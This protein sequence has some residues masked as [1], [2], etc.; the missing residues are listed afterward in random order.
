MKKILRLS[1]L[2]MLCVISCTYATEYYV[3][4]DGND[5]NPGT[6]NS[7]S[8]AFRTVTKACQIA[9]PGDIVNIANGR[10]VE[11]QINIDNKNGSKSTRLIIRSINKHGAVI[12]STS[13]TH[14]ISISNSTGVTIDGLEVTFD[15]PANSYHFGILASG[16]GNWI[17]V[18][19]C[20]VHD[21]GSS[22]IQINNADHVLIEGNV[23]RHNAAN[24]GNPNGS[25]ISVY[26]PRH[27]SD[28]ITG[29][30]GVIIRN[31]ICF[32]NVCSYADPANGSITDAPT[33]GNGI[34]LDDFNNTQTWNTGG[35]T[36]GYIHPSLVENNLS[37]NN[38]GRGI[39][40]FQTNY[41]T[42]R[43]NT[44]YHNNYE[45][46]KYPQYYGWNGDLN[47]SRES[48]GC[49]FYNNIAVMKSTNTPGYGLLVTYDTDVQNNIVIGGAG[50]FTSSN[51]STNPATG[52]L[53]T[54]NQIRVL[55]D[56]SYI[57]FVNPTYA[58]TSFSS[59]NPQLSAYFGLQ[60]TSPA[61]NAGLNSQS[62]SSDLEGKV[63]PI[64]S[65]VDIGAYE[66]GTPG[67]DTQAPTAPSGLSAS[68]ITQTSFTLSWIPSTD[69]VAVTNY[70]IF[71]GSATTPVATT[72][73]TNFV[74][75]GLI[76][77]TTY[78]FTVKAKDAAGNVSTAS[79]AL[80]VTTSAPITGD[81]LNGQ[82]YTQYGP[83]VSAA[84]TA[85]AGQSPAFSFT[86]TTVDYP[87]G[88]GTTSPASTLWST[89]LG[90]DGTGAPSGEQL[91][92]STLKLSGYIQIKPEHD[93]QTG[94]ST[95][96]VDF[97]LASQGYAALTVNGT[98]V[99]LNEANWA[100]GT[101]SARV[102]FPSA[103]YYTIEVLNSV[104][105]DNGGVELYS[106]IP[107]TTNPGRG[108]TAATYLIPQIYLFKTIPPATDTQAP[109][110]P[111][112]LVSSAITQTS[113][114]LSWSAST[115]NV[116]VTSYDIFQGS[117]T[118]PIGNST[119]TSYTVNGLTA[120]TTYSF[121]VKAKDAA[122]NVSAAS[123]A[124][125]VTTSAPI[126]GDGLNGQFYTQYGPSVSAART[127]IAGQTPAFSFTSNAVDYPSGTTTTSS[128]S[129]TWSTFLGTDGTGAPSGEQLET[130][131]LKLS[132]YIQIKPEHDVQ[133][134]NSTI[135]VDF[136]LASQGYAALTVNGTQ[137]VL[138]EAN[139]AFGT[140]SARVSFPSAG[141]Y[142]IEVLNSV[143]WDNGG[144]ELYSSIPGTTNPGRGTTA[145][146]YLIPKAVLFK[147]I[148]S[149]ARVAFAATQ[150]S[151]ESDTNFTLYPNPSVS[152]NAVT[153][154]G[155]FSDTKVLV[156]IH[157]I[158]G[159]V[160]Y[161]NNSVTEN[162]SIWLPTNGLKKGM[163]VITLNS[164]NTSSQKKLVIE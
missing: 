56:Q 95:I 9:T 137:V 115:D 11:G 19:N 5:N 104:S 33:D 163:Y 32:E 77:G 155:T 129:T 132:G 99:V 38:G 157:D 116:A 50:Q 97:L 153:V 13:G 1:L 71:Q 37:F 138:N 87:S 42:V 52:T 53:P 150:N 47:C 108:T 105:W 66:Y 70:D 141:Y 81:G 94:N 161:K 10:Y 62:P 84:R 90:T 127:A 152:G 26:H 59:T 72:N 48:L 75:T 140:S 122:G 12:A 139:W 83:S 24:T 114:T 25:G 15:N 14:A 57:K 51:P 82:F 55:S 102:S 164:G 86:A 96:E 159:R 43:N 103:G 22:G 41:S 7:S 100:F 135:E 101:S 156:T 85:I 54:T 93:V 112:S 130:S 21:I 61:I 131:T 76:A 3:R 91:E 106:S 120:G 92:T 68:G 162:G 125:S 149:G 123:T 117:S 134:G 46:G 17:T 4:T 29:E 67:T 124:L 8:G 151:L 58:I 121:T 154:K 144:V 145:A 63:R 143:S 119:S 69:N 20:Y 28:Y 142:T 2:F 136:L 110:I 158:T 45:L 64:N 78:S 147:T 126:T 79:T 80:S 65:T 39:H 89:F 49:K 36:G 60:S 160:V 40:I 73:T 88:S 27:A 35:E 74:I 16:F 44:C 31:N 148:P 118:T 113:F 34:I 98:Q 18:S 23:V 146:T 6:I 133:T 107:G 128:Q 109:T 111:T 30:W